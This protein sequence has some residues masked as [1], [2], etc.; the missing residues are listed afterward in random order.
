MTLDEVVILRLLE[1]T[2]SIRLVGHLTV[3]IGVQGY[4]ADKTL[5]PDRAL[6]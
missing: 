1:G 5:R 4:L 3:G 2:Q 6:E